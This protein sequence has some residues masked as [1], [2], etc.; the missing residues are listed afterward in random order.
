MI[1]TGYDLIIIFRKI[2]IYKLLNF[3]NNS[4]SCSRNSFVCI[5]KIIINDLVVNFANTIKGLVKIE[6]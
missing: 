5:R 6:I 4:P 3:I 1:A 2:V